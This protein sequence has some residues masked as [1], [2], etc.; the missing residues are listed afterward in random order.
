MQASGRIGKPGLRGTGD[1]YKG[2]CWHKLWC[3]QGY[4]PLSL[5]WAGLD[6]LSG[7]DGGLGTVRAEP[8]VGFVT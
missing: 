2:G 1:G 3:S 7:V 4:G 6:A 5:T 8:S